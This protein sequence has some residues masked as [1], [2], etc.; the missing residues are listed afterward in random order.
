MPDVQ[1]IYRQFEHFY[2]PKDVESSKSFGWQDSALRNIMPFSWCKRLRLNL[3]GD[4]PVTTNCE[5]HGKLTVHLCELDGE[6][7]D[8][9]LGRYVSKP[10]PIRS[11]HQPKQTQYAYIGSKSLPGPKAP[12]NI[13][14]LRT[15]DLLLPAFAIF[16]FDYR[17]SV[18]PKPPDDTNLLENLHSV[19]PPPG[20][21]YLLESLSACQKLIIPKRESI[22]TCPLTSGPATSQHRRDE[23]RQHRELERKIEEAE[24]KRRVE[25]ARHEGYLAGLREAQAILYEELRMG[26]ADE[27]R[28]ESSGS[29]NR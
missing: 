3:R 5:L 28:A 17:E 10:S 9:T 24:T 23:E 19:P 27:G 26:R 22:A 12:L 21:P 14:R 16:E 7:L 13:R 8:P 11:K 15:L 29:A 1:V 25:Q 2:I 4:T 18:L 6:V 20:M